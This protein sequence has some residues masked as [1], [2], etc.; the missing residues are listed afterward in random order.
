[1]R[2]ALIKPKFIVWFSLFSLLSC[3][4]IVGTVATAE[5]LW[6]QAGQ[7]VSSNVDLN[8][9]NEVTGRISVV[10]G[11]TEGVN[12][13]VVSPSDKV[14]LP[15]QKVVVTDFK[16]SASEKGTYHFIFD[17]SL[18]SVDKTISFNYD[19]RHYWFGMQ[20][21]VFLMIVVVLLGALAL[22]VYALA[23]KG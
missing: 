3:C 11:E 6:A 20:Q 1:M 5:S 10:G 23:S 18:S 21:E 12:F 2:V 19:V 4:L 8:V 9:D 13:T 15:F 7:T 17:N 22:I 14:V 16:F